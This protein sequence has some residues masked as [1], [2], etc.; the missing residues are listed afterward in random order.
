MAKWWS[1]AS[2]NG[3]KSVLGASKDLRAPSGLI[4]EG[5]AADL[6][7]L[8][9]S[10]LDEEG[11]VVPNVDWWG[12]LMSRAHKGLIERVYARGKRVLDK[13]LVT[14]LDEVAMK[15]EFLASY[16]KAISIDPDWPSWQEDLNQF[17]QAALS[18]YGQTH[19]LGCV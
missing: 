17:H 4:R 10:A 18:F 19:W 7:C 5:H 6:I 15:K 16:R 8:D 9:I 12:K 3:R 13:G 2:Q 1:F 11:G 14:G